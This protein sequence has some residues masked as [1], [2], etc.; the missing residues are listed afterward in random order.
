MRRFCEL[1]SIITIAWMPDVT[2]D[3]IRGRHD[4]LGYLKPT[5]VTPG[6][7]RGPAQLAPRDEVQGCM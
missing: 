7:T 6:L 1:G 4:S 5:P 3:L 2:P